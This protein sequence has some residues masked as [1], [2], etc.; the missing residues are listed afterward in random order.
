MPTFELETAEGPYT[1]PQEKKAPEGT[2]ASIVRCNRVFKAICSS[3]SREGCGAGGDMGRSV[4]RLLRYDQLPAASTA[5]TA[6]PRESVDGLFIVL[7]RQCLMRLEKL[8]E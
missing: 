7:A 1:L 3:G 8:Q 4:L 2:S 5:C 6:V